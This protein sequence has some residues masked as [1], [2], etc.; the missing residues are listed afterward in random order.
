MDGISHLAGERVT[1]LKLGDREYTLTTQ[2]L[3]EYSEREQYILS[4]KPDPLAL[5]S[6]IPGDIPAELRS[7]LQER[8][9]REASLPRVVSMEDEAAFDGSLRGMGWR[10]WRAL[11]KHHPEI[12]SVDKAVDLIEEAGA[13]AVDAAR[14]AIDRAEEKDLL[15]NSQPSG[16]KAPDKTQDQTQTP[17]GQ[18]HRF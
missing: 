6:R 11:R 14:R 8:A 1:K 18:P 15:G 16:S 5:L 10:L 12:D 2:T 4:L 9:W 13:E 7:Q 3:A 17:P